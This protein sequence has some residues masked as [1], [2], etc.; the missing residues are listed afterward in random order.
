M[1]SIIILLTIIVCLGMG[2]CSSNT[3]DGPR[4][5]DTYGG[6][7]GGGYGRY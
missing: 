7:G 6:G 1:R 4:S 2:A 3:G 5:P